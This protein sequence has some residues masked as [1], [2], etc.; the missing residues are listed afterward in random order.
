MAGRAEL[1]ETI[2]A[3]DSPAEQ[4]RRTFEVNVVAVAELTSNT[5]RTPGTTRH[6][7]PHR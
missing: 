2:G 7:W 3:A 5:C 1:T 4:W 6:L